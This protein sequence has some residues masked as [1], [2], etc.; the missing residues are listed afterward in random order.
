MAGALATGAYEIAALWAW[1]G[2]TASKGG[3]RVAGIVGSTA[4]IPATLTLGFFF[5]LAATFLGLR[6]GLAATFRGLRFGLAATFRGLRFGLAT[7]FGGLRFALDCFFLMWRPRTRRILPLESKPGVTDTRVPGTS[8]ALGPERLGPTAVSPIE[9]L[10]EVFGM[11]PIM[12]AEKCEWSNETSA[13]SV[14]LH[15][16]SVS[17]KAPAII[18]PK[19]RD[20]TALPASIQA[21]MPDVM[22]PLASYLKDTA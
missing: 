3:G 13:A 21:Q 1:G 11:W 16:M 18:F 15:A 14:W 20:T 8:F 12:M 7:T 5:G 17:T 19:K 9:V 4:W 10:G 22:T 6:F 2:A